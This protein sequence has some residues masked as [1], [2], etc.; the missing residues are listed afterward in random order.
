[1]GRKRTGRR[2]GRPVDPHARRRQ[3]T[4]AGRRGE[5]DRGSERLRAKKRQ[6]TSRED[7]EMTPA[8]A[9]YGLAHLDNAQ[10]TKLGVITAML[11]NVQTAMGKGSLSVGALWSALV[12]RSH[13]RIS[14][15][16]L[17]GDRG[18]RQQLARVC[19]Q[20]DGCRSLVIALAEERTVPP[21]VVR[22]MARQLTDRDLA[23]L[24]ILR[25]GLDGLAV[26]SQ[27]PD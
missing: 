24:E 21:I 10:Y 9:L 11:R 6:L 18:G 12:D 2:R 22:A 5:V 26:R 16:P 13:T 25:Q 20:L 17:L 14:S 7:V 8:G 3:T 23:T 1:M 15:L 4:R 27:E 19:R